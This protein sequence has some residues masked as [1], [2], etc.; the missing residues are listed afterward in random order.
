MFSDLRLVRPLNVDIGAS[1]CRLTR[2]DDQ[3]YLDLF[4]DALPI[5]KDEGFL[6][7]LHLQQLG[8]GCGWLSLAEFYTAFKTSFGES[9]D[10]FDD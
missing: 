4:Q 9:G 10:Y 1:R 2:L 7:M 3:R 8:N 5:Q 6:M